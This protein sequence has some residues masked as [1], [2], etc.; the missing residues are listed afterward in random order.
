MSMTANEA[1]SGGGGGIMWQG[2]AAVEI[3]DHFCGEVAP[4]WDCEPGM[5]P[6]VGGCRPCKP[7]EFKLSCGPQQC[8]TCPPKSRVTHEETGDTC[9]CDPGYSGLDGGPCEAC[10]AGRYKPSQGSA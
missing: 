8:S 4:L 7:W 2:A 5:E 1:S 3:L 10:G 6:G 9:T